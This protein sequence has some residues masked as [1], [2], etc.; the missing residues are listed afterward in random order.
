ME[1]RSLAW[2]G[3]FFTTEL[4]GKPQGS[5]Y[6]VTML[7]GEAG[8]GDEDVVD[9][10]R[11]PD[12]ALCR[13]ESSPRG[14]SVLP[15]WCWGRSCRHYRNALALAAWP[16][17]VLPFSDLSL[18]SCSV[19]GDWTA[20]PRLFQSCYFMITLG[21]GYGMPLRIAGCISWDKPVGE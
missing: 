5:R 19:R 2:A 11:Y 9:G 10:A 18:P 14:S 16:W 21:A 15:S 17:E 6:P 8:A 4:A 7:L 13:Q 20:S 3:G 1:S 12:S